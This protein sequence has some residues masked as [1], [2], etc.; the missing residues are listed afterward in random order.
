MAYYW[1]LYYCRFNLKLKKERES[2]MYLL[3]VIS[4]F[5]FGYMLYVLVKPEKF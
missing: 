4:I 5:M 1:H 2:M 3:F